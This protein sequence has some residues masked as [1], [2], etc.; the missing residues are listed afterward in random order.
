MVMEDYNNYDGTNNDNIV[1]SDV[2]H[3][4]ETL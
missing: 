3:T 1:E 4:V 2:L